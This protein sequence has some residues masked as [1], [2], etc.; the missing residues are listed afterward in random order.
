MEN[1]FFFSP[2]VQKIPESRSSEGYTKGSRF[3]NFNAIKIKWC[4]QINHDCHYNSLWVSDAPQ[5]QI[6]RPNA[7]QTRMA[8]FNLSCRILEMSNSFLFVIDER[9]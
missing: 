8:G 4:I 2:F 9:E 7:S 6:S 5:K 1:V 3:C